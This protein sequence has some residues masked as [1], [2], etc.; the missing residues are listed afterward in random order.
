MNATLRPVARPTANRPA[1]SAAA[2]SRRLLDCW[3]ERWA[4]RADQ[5]W[6]GTGDPHAG[7]YY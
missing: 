7:R 6:R 4:E 2:D 1:G 5:R 3:I